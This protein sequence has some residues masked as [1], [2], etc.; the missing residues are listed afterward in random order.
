MSLP[1]FWKKATE[2][3]GRGEQTSCSRGKREEMRYVL[4]KDATLIL[5]LL[6]CCKLSLKPHQLPWFSLAWWILSC[7][8]WLSGLKPTEPPARWMRSVCPVHV[9]VNH[10]HASQPM[11]RIRSI[12]GSWLLIKKR[13][14]LC[15]TKQWSHINS[16]SW[17]KVIQHGNVVMASFM[18]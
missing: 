6:Y 7:A 4:E 14:Y 10:S 15:K 5:N 8:W 2:K 1:L 13:P 12:W 11:E 17:L 18:P 9:C 3:H 16:L